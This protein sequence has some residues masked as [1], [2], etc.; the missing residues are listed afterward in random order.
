MVSVATVL[1][2]ICIG[3]IGAPLTEVVMPRFEVGLRAADGGGNNSVAGTGGTGGAGG[4]GT[5]WDS[6]HGS[7]G[8]GLREG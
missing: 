1:V 4:T 2:S 3:F 7:G 8:G 5:E 6:T